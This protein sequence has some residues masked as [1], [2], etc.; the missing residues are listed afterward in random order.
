MALTG[1]FFRTREKAEKGFFD[2]DNDKDSYE[3]SRVSNDKLDI[4]ETCTDKNDLQIIWHISTAIF[5]SHGCGYQELAYELRD[6]VQEEFIN[7][8][9]KELRGKRSP[10]LDKVCHFAF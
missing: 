9:F 4:I 1:I 2:M 7:V 10:Y 6:A 5:V 3:I 8:E